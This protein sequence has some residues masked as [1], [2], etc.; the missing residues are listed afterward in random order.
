[1]NIK[2]IGA[3]C[4]ALVATTMLVAVAQ[5]NSEDA[6]VRQ[7]VDHYLHGLKFNDI[8]SLKSAFF[9]EAKLMFVKRDGQLGQLTQEQ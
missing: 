9:P 4:V 7:T 6:A 3:C 5:N 8:A 1:M 2:L